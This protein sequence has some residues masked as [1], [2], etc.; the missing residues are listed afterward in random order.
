MT[1][2]QS[3]KITD[4]VN[5]LDRLRIELDTSDDDDDNSLATAIEEAINRLE[6]YL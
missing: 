2:A 4:I 1:E 6:E 3:K 5:D